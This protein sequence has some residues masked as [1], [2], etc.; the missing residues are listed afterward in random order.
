MNKMAAFEGKSLSELLKTYTLESLEDNYDA[1]IAELAY[2]EY[3]EDN[4]KSRPIKELV[5]EL[6]S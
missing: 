5:R 6:E 3:I 2:D 4:K 1:H